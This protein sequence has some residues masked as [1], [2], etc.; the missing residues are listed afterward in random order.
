MV[1]W[2]DGEEE[3]QLRLVVR[4]QEA[5]RRWV[6]KKAMLISIDGARGGPAVDPRW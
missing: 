6:W 5:E 1:R 3:E 2:M 4:L